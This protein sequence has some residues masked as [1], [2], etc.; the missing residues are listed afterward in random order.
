MSHKKGVP[1][2]LAILIATLVAFVAPAANAAPHNATQTSSSTTATAADPCAGR[3]QTYI[4]QTFFR[5]PAVY[6][7]R[8]GTSS[9]GYIHLVAGHEYDPSMIAVTVAQGTIQPL[10]VIDYWTQ[11]CP[12]RGFRVVYNDGALNGTGV[13]PQGIITAYPLTAASA[14]ARHVAC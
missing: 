8:C 12:S 5:G 9:W 3:S 2:L 11:T 4:V 13:R 10:N 1:P 7:L 14:V 6:P